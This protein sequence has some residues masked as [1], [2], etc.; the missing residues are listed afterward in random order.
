[1]RNLAAAIFFLLCACSFAGCGTIMGGL[2]KGVKVE[3]EPSG[4]LAVNMDHSCVTPCTVQIRRS[5][6][7]E[8]VIRVSKEGYRP[9]DVHLERGLNG[10][11]VVQSASIILLPGALVDLGTGSLYSV[12]PKELRVR[13]TPVENPDGSA[14][15]QVEDYYP[16]EEEERQKD[17]K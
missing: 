12:E 14:T 6:G 5:A 3:T 7:K 1:M 8:I 17:E 4:A 15:I 13:M 11:F 2:Y 10:W 16:L 9:V